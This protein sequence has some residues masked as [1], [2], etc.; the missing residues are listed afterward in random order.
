[1]LFIFGFQG[2]S[3]RTLPLKGKGFVCDRTLL[4]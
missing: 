4:T 3:E 2:A 1:M